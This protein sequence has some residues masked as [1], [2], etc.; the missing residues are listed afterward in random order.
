MKPDEEAKLYLTEDVRDLPDY[1]DHMTLEDFVDCCQSGGFIDF[2]GYAKYATSDKMS[3]INAYP[4]DVADS[5]IDWRWTH[6]VW[7]NK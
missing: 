2:D 3:D 4:S 7:F 6:V 1:G 5:D